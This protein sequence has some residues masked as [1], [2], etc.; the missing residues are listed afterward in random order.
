VA[1]GRAVA[2][3]RALVAPDV[4]HPADS[5][6]ARK[7]DRAVTKQCDKSDQKTQRKELRQMQQVNG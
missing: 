6:A 7:R 1:M 4:A 3:S 5:E 2:R